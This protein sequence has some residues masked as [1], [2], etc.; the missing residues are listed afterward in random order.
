MS[1]FIISES[2]KLENKQIKHPLEVKGKVPNSYY[3]K[4]K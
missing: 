1:H 2:D 4:V 3:D